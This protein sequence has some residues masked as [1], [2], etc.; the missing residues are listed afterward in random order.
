MEVGP[1]PTLT[2]WRQSKPLKACISALEHLTCEY[3]K[4]GSLCQAGRTHLVMRTTHL[5]QS[6]SQ[7]ILRTVADIARMVGDDTASSVAERTLYLLHRRGSGQALCRAVAA[8]HLDTATALLDGAMGGSLPDD[9]YRSGELASGHPLAA[10][11][12]GR[13]APASLR[14]LTRNGVDVGASAYDCVDVDLDLHNNIASAS[15]VGP[16]WR[17]RRWTTPERPAA[18]GFTPVH[19]WAAGTNPDPEVLSLLSA[20]GKSDRF[21]EKADARGRTPLLVA[22]SNGGC[23]RGGAA[24]AVEAL[25]G[26]HLARFGTVRR[27]VDAR[28]EHGRGALHHCARSFGGPPCCAPGAAEAARLVIGAGIDLDAA[29]DDG[30]TALLDAA[31]ALGAPDPRCAAEALRCVRALLAAGA[32]PSAPDRAGTTPLHASAARGAS[33][34]CAALLKHGAAVAAVDARGRTPLAC[35]C[36]RGNWRTAEFLIENGAKVD[37]ASIIAAK[38]FEAL[39]PEEQREKQ[40]EPRFA[41]QTLS[42]TP[43]RTPPSPR[44]RSPA[45]PPPAPVLTSLLLGAKLR[46]EQETSES[47]DQE[48][49]GGEASFILGESG[50]SSY[51][52]NE[53]IFLSPGNET[54]AGK[55]MLKMF[56]ELPGES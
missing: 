54:T 29:G 43:K 13:R 26:V 18:E 32:D 45:S 30:A 5:V 37:A 52:H 41:A 34:A 4:L 23:G 1:E 28:D 49:E 40:P 53:P 3:E 16:W 48:E 55:R 7:T 6:I 25:L 39:R 42:S 21:L 44:A 38:G 20:G 27:L 10:A 9:G 36:A 31:T 15:G 24:R 35:A 8:G 17:P 19:C 11:V 2:M 14:W 50:S 47:D 51:A 46:Q 56:A 22:C 33:A 12:T